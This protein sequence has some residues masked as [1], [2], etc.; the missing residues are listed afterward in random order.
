MQY[1]LWG[2]WRGIALMN[3]YVPS[4]LH[5]NM[6]THTNGMLESPLRKTG[7]LK[8]SCMWLSSQL[9]T[10]RFVCSLH[11]PTPNKR[12]LEQ[13][14]CSAGSTV[15]TEVC[16][17]VTG[18]TGGQDFSWVLQHMVL[19]PIT[20]TKVHLFINKCL[21]LCWKWGTERQNVLF[22][23]FFNFNF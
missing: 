7:L 17:P 11:P 15:D 5:L 12:G 10:L 14:C 6:C 1:Y 21:T 4:L 13:V 18:C 3:F 16:L 2:Q 9:S 23:N 8:F 22:F 19:A 20:P